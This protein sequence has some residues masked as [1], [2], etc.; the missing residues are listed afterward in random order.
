[1]NQ[2]KKKVL[3]C[4]R[5]FNHGGVP[6][7]LLQLLRLFDYSRYDVEV[8][9]GDQSG[10]YKESFK[11]FNVLPQDML[12]WLL[13]SNYRK[14]RGLKKCAAIAVK[15]IRHGFK[16]LGLDLYDW[17]IAKT[18]QKLS[19][20]GVEVAIS[21]AEGFP[22]HCVSQMSTPRKLTWVHC[23]YDW[24]S[25]CDD[26]RLELARYSSFDKIVC[27]SKRTKEAF[28]NVFPTL[29][30]KTVTVNNVVDIERIKNHSSQD[31]HIEKR[32]MEAPI[33]IL[34][35]GRVCWQKQFDA[36]PQIMKEVSLKIDS[37]W[38]IIGGGPDFE[39]ETVKQEIIKHGMQEY[40]YMLGPKSNPYAYMKHA[41]VLVVPSRY[42]S[43][44]TVVNESKIVGTPIVCN[45]FSS[46]YEIM[47][48]NCGVISTIDKMSDS[49]VSILLDKKKMERI[50]NYLLSF[51]YDNQSIMEKIYKCI[52][53]ND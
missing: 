29:A 41:D 48:D 20:R 5:D 1:M 35:V 42:E 3:F 19:R 51:S 17:Y 32:F 53:K 49:I 31:S 36:I 9:C 47:D 13:M 4:L 52:N 7:C 50:K 26:S 23:E 22:C 16:K 12:M 33:R 43:Y 24:V 11:E 18:A 45:D 38:F 25:P 28:D 14:L 6:S 40:V 46:V 37:K 8:Y 21:F 44:P 15:M 34:S 27:V 30:G 2:N 10:V 39:V